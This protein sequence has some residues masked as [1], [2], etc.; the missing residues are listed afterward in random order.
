MLIP[1]VVIVGMII[2][3]V[4]GMAERYPGGILFIMPIV[5]TIW[6]LIGA[7]K[8]RKKIKECRDYLKALYIKVLPLHTP[9]F[10]SLWVALL[11]QILL[12]VYDYAYY[13][14]AFGCMAMTFLSILGVVLSYNRMATRRMPQFD[15]MGGDDS[16]KTE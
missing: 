4:A 8:E 12:P 13:A 9:A 14:V 10:I 16:A 5:I 6:A 7:Y 3:E 15:H 11:V 2:A 1:Y